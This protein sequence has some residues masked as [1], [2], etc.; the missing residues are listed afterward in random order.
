MCLTC[1]RHFSISHQTALRT[2]IDLK[3]KTKTKPFDLRL[4]V[5][6]SKQYSHCL[7]ICWFNCLILTLVIIKGQTDQTQ[8]EIFYNVYSITR[9][10]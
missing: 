7:L 5:P 3:N 8:I 9:E 10:N 4:H 2:L 1:L 6:L